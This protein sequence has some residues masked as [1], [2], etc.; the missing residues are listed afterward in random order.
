MSRGLISSGPPN[1]GAARPSLAGKWAKESSPHGRLDA[2]AGSSGLSELA[3][4]AI[5][6]F[7]IATALAFYFGWAR[8]AAYYRFFGLDASM[9]GLSTADY[10]LRSVGVLY[11][12]LIGLSLVALLAMITHARLITFLGRFSLR[13]SM[14]VLDVAGWGLI[15]SAAVAFVAA[16]KWQSSWAEPAIPWLITGGAC[17][18]A[19]SWLLRSILTNKQAANRFQLLASAGLALGGL[20]W[21]A[22]NYAEYTGSTQAQREAGEIS[23]RTDVAVY[24]AQQLHLGGRNGIIEDESRGENAAYHYRY[25]NLRLLTYSGGRYYLLPIE[26]RHDGTVPVIIIGESDS[27]RVE[28]IESPYN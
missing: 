27:I 16:V 22:G 23:Y 25:I 6:Q 26:W 15:T 28:I 8:T 24:S 7:S 5:G 17:A 21:L 19:Y 2:K 3:K 1:R 10:V 9:I 4:I 14:A 13:D 11:W 12:P 18:L 20:F